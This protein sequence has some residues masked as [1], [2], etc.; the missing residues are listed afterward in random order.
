MP[1]ASAA[2]TRPRSHRG[3]S[4]RA[5]LAYDLG[6]RGEPA[7]AWLRD[8]PEHAGEYERGVDDRDAAQAGAPP[9][10]RNDP[11]DPAR[12]ADEAIPVSDAD[13]REFGDEPAP[14]DESGRRSLLPSVNFTSS[15]G[16]VTAQVSSALIGL[17]LYAVVVNFARGGWPQVTRWFWAKLTNA[18]GTLP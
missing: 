18:G 12:H 11:T 13:R 3:G 2:G 6:R 1:A 4:A 10:E 9:R 16:G 17:G 8:H 7:P 5:N 15:G 14:A